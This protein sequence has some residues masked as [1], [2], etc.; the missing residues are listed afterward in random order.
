MMN[1]T[2]K[3]SGADALLTRIK[4]AVKELNE[5][6]TYDIEIKEHREKRSLDANAYCWVL[7]SKLAV[8]LSKGGPTVSPESIYRDLIP[9]VGENYHDTLIRN[10][11]VSSWADNWGAGRLGWP[12][13]EL[14]E[15]KAKPGYTWVRCYYGSSVYDSA[16]MAR[17]ID[18]VVQECKALDIE[19]MTPLELERIKEAWN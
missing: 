9:D 5:N 10:D 19:T 16:Q 17:L 18:L 13:K 2:F 4:W 15:C 12:C 7:L 6:R 1:W 8:E 14:G 3:P 11:A